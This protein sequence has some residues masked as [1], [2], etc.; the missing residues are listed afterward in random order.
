MKQFILLINISCL[1]TLLNVACNHRHINCAGLKTGKFLYYS[2]ITNKKYFI[3]RNDSIQIE[4]DAA[5][6]KATKSK[7]IWV[8][9]CEYY[10]TGVPDSNK[11]HDNIDS[12]FQA[13]PIKTTIVE[14]TPS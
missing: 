10:L 13:T 6:K 9:D 5:S 2:S 8:N 12:F 7:I 11:S 14:A 4:V 3:E 1:I